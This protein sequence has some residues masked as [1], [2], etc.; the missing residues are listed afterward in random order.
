M[1]VGKT[2]FLWVKKKSRMISVMTS[3]PGLP[4][5]EVLVEVAGTEKFPAL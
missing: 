5:P 3:F 2:V 4:L 1:S